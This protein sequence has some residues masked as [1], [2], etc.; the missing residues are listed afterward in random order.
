L[1]LF[2]T[3]GIT[4]AVFYSCGDDDNSGGGGNNGGGGGDVGMWFFVLF[5][6]I[7]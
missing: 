6:P 2:L 7:W 4:T 5:N 1:G 3:L